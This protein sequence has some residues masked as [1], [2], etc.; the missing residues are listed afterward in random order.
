MKILHV[1]PA[2]AVIADGPRLTP[3]TV[4]LEGRAYL[5]FRG[6]N[7]YY[8]TKAQRTAFDRDC[9]PEGGTYYVEIRDGLYARVCRDS[10]DESFRQHA[11]TAN[12]WGPHV[13]KRPV[14]LVS[15]FIAEHLTI[16]DDTA[17]YSDR[18]RTA[19]AA[20]TAEREAENARKATERKEREERETRERIARNT[21]KFKADGYIDL[22]GFE[23]LCKLHGVFIPIQ[24]IG[25]ARKSVTEVS[26]SSFRVCG[27]AKPYGISDASRAL[28][29]VLN[30][31]PEPVLTA[32][33]EAEVNRLFG[34]SA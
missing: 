12:E 21:D 23:E 16:A 24:T 30:P 2:L 26:A 18:Q 33:Q 27:K 4:E 20:R 7:I 31:K 14:D 25:S 28:R 1:Y 34:V 6:V 19:I 11:T 17:G 22:A 29:D 8:D 3:E 15:T 10:S 32:T 9:K 5:V 13:G